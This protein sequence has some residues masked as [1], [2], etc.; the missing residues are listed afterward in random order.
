LVYIIIKNAFWAPIIIIIIII[1]II[2]KPAENADRNRKK[3]Y[4]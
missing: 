2:T 3:A 4:I 1:I